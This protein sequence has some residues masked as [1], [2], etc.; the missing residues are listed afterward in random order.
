MSLCLPK[1]NVFI[2]GCIAWDGAISCA[3]RE[4][5]KD[6][7]QGKEKRKHSIVFGWPTSFRISA[8]KA[9]HL[10]A[11]NA[12]MFS[13]PCHN[14]ESRKCKKLDRQTRRKI[15]LWRSIWFTI[16]FLN[17]SKSNFRP[18][19][20]I[21]LCLVCYFR[22]FQ[23]YPKRLLEY[24]RPL[25]DFFRYDSEASIEAIEMYSKN[26][27]CCIFPKRRIM[28]VNPTVHRRKKVGSSC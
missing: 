17:L 21:S 5:W 18:F 24:S 22:F 16:V 12:E 2:L 26:L 3:W 14:Y 4:A 28:R 6:A 15:Q 9:F 11:F 1:K 20:T 7:I 10:T 19:Y 27:P 25:T 8:K 13:R 23:S